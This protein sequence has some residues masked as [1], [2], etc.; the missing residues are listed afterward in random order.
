MQKYGGS[1]IC[2]CVCTVLILCG[3]SSDKV[4]PQGKRVAVLEQVSA[5]KPEAAN[6][7]ALIKISSPQIL[8]NWTQ[9]ELNAEHVTPNIK[10][11][12][13]FVRAWK[14]DFGAGASKRE[15]LIAKPLVEGETVYTLDADGKLTA[16]KIKDGEKRW[17]TKLQAEN[18]NIDETALKGVG[19]ALQNGNLYVVTGFGTVVAVKAKDGTQ[20]WSRNLNVPLRIAPTIASGKIFVQSVDNRFF[21]LSAATGEVLW[22]YDIALENTTMIGGAGAS[23]AQNLDMVLAGFSNGEIQAFN[24]TLG[25]PLWSDILIS[26]RQAYSST[27]LH[28]IKASA[29]IEGEKAYAL[30]SSDVLAAIDL[31]S[32]NRLWEKEIGGTVTPLLN[33]NTLYVVTSDND[34]VAIN[35]DNG[36]ILWATPLELGDKASDVTVYAPLMLNSRL[37]VALSNGHVL[38][39]DPQSGKK[40]TMVD[41]DEKLNSAPIAA[42]GYIFFVT[43]NAKL[44][45]YQ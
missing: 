4:L 38:S 29:V 43:K 45:A 21:A 39:Y 36:S 26:N 30:G 11:G 12:T 16:F 10:T 44:L 15:F 24:A 6:A 1:A 25:T 3:C 8:Q 31:R 28:T 19:M 27:Y 17:S 33:G 2:G 14:A 35:K 40:I 22:D 42:G 20:I 7:S 9:N 32:G 41:L 23:Y 18:D 13:D 37:V 5:V 34:F